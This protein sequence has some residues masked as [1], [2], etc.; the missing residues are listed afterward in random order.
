MPIKFGLSSSDTV[1]WIGQQVKNISEPGLSI[2][3]K[4]FYRSC[5][6]GPLKLT[7]GDFVL[8]T[9]ADSNDPESLDTC[10]IGEIIRMYEVFEAPLGYDQFRA[11]IRW[12]SRCN[13]LPKHILFDENYVFDF[14]LEIVQDH[15]PFDRDISIE[16]IFRKCSIV[17]GMEDKAPISILGKKFVRQPT[18]VC[19]Y[20]LIKIKGRNKY[21]IVPQAYPNDLFDESVPNKTNKLSLSRTPTSSHKNVYAV[22][23][24]TEK[25]SSKDGVTPIKI[26]KSNN[27]NSVRRKL[28]LDNRNDDTVDD[29]D[30]DILNYSIVNEAP[31]DK[32]KFKIKL[33]ISEKQH[34]ATPIHEDVQLSAKRITSRKRSQDLGSEMVLREIDN[35]STPKKLPRRQ[36]IDT[37]TPKG[38]VISTR[39][40]SILKTPGTPTIGTPKKTIQLSNIVEEY[41]GGTNGLGTPKLTQLKHDATTP[42]SRR[43]RKGI[44]HNETDDEDDDYVPTRTPKSTRKTD[45]K[46][47]TPKSSAR[48]P[49]SARKLLREGVITPKLA[50]REH[51][52]NKRK[53]DIQLTRERLHVSAAPKSLPCRESEF[54]NIYSFLERKIVDQIGGC[55]YVSGVPGT[56]KTATVTEVIQTLKREEAV[57]EIPEFQYIEINGLRLTEPQQAYV[58]IYRQ[59][60]GKTIAW[61]QAYN[62]LHKRFMTPA[63]KRVPTVL[64]IDELDIICNRRQDVVYNLLDWSTKSASKLAVI[65]IANT[66]DLP[67]RFLHGK[68]TS[69]LGLTRLTFLPYTFKQLQEIVTDRLAG[70]DS[71]KSEAVQLVSR[72]IAAVSGDARRALDICRRATEIAEDTNI[73][74]KQ[75]VVVNLNHVQQ[76]LG[77]MISSG[78]I[79]AIK[80][81]SK[82]EKLFLQAVSSETIRTGVEETTFLGV[83]TQMETLAAF[84]GLTLPSTGHVLKI[85]SKL[86]EMRLIICE[87]SR[88]DLYRKILLNV[89]SDDIHFA[90][91]GD[92]QNW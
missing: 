9:N 53:S 37:N 3:D 49:S 90:L 82:F 39:R 65:T 72:K 29:E 8:I 77:E 80:M 1:E 74:G 11:Y 81:C 48:T 33:R 43:K 55:M 24:S 6:F 84:S 23:K 54:D 70:C 38:L 88:N 21:K 36:S 18:Y 19:R 83:Y 85:C 25:G 78:K 51:A 62:L 20:K 89:S 79:Q 16:T 35:N 67:E 7:V 34:K 31:G 45:S 42:L 50:M 61:K 60:T 64:L 69:R 52:N 71:F 32:N 17:F 2:A 22:V 13:E 28:S 66:M 63:P 86:G 73:D 91:Q 14:D 10:N 57:E 75:K 47:E 26:V 40:R 5:I 58:Q 56:G 46:T 87:P 92:I 30:D 4:Y 12:Y 15:R 76:A 27:E 68:V 44:N 59:L 41:G